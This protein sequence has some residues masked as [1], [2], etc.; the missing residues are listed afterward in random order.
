[1]TASYSISWKEINQAGE[2]ESRQLSKALEFQKKFD[3]GLILGPVRG[4]FC[5][6][7]VQP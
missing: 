6:K 5:V 2:A 3:V 7:Q 4:P 1:M